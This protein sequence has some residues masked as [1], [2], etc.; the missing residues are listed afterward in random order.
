MAQKIPPELENELRK[1]DNLRHQEEGYSNMVRAY[2]EQVEQLK[3]TLDQLRKQ[4][5]DVVTYKTVGQVMFKVE[6]P[7]MIEELEDK[8]RELDS[9]I[10][11]AEAKLKTLT[12]EL[13]EL[14]KSIQLEIAKRN[15]TLQ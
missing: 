4:P 1:Y 3:E 13:A 12:P 7:S 11:K 8:V 10:K 15:L 14:Q 6:K 9:S 5:D 2:K